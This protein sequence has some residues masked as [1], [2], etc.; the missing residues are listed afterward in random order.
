VPELAAD[1]SARARK[2][3]PA[4]HVAFFA[5]RQGQSR[6]RK[7]AWN[8]TVAATSRSAAGKLR[9]A[10]TSPPGR[11]SA[12]SIFPCLCSPPNLKACRRQAVLLARSR[13]SGSSRGT[14]PRPP[15]GLRPGRWLIA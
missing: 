14:S 13:G 10:T 8:Q 15:R 9:R 6:T 12:T 2:R 5:P 1:E 4:K 7:I 11:R 3:A